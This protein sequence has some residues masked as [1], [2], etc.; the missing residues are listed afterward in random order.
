M[1]QF[2]NTPYYVSDK[3]QVYRRGKVRPLKPEVFPLGYRRVTLSIDGITQRF[4]IH[5]MVAEMYCPK[6]H[7]HTEVNHIDGIPGN[8][9]KENLEWVTRSQNQIHANNMGKRPHLNASKI[10]SQIICRQSEEYFKNKLGSNF[11]ALV[12]ESPRNFIVFKC[13][14][15]FKELKCR[16]DSSPLKDAV[17]TCKKCKYKMKI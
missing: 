8:D 6:G 7:E 2:R 3:G 5:R 13:S 16:T 4:F 17:P 15:C 10:A 12:N 14:C 1:L 11:L 9:W